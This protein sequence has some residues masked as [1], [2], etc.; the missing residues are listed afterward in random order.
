MRVEDAAIELG[1]GRTLGYSTFGDLDGTPVIAFHGTPGCSVGFEFLDAPARALGVHLLAPDRPGYRRSTRRAGLRVADVAAD[2]VELADALALGTPHLFGWSGGA[3]YA[4]ATAAKHGERFGAVAVAGGVAPPDAEGWIHA[5]TAADQLAFRLARR[6]PWLLARAFDAWAAAA[7]LQPRV[8]EVLFR[9]ELGPSDLAVVDH[10]DALRAP[11]YLTAP[12]EPSS[13]GALDDYVA[14]A[15]D[16]GVS[17]DTLDAR[18]TIWQGTADPF[19]APWSARVLARRLPRAEL[20]Q[21]VGEGHLF[22]AT[23][24]EEILAGLLEREAV[25][26]E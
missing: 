23:H 15:D 1:D 20:I 6:A 19:V 7:R 10:V 18:V 16:W 13:A 8:A 24:A 22:V 26:G 4:L 11:R 14:L 2:M 5:F 25:P 9:R 12:F 17:L 21:C 3:P